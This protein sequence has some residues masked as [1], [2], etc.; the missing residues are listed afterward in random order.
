ME[1]C[2]APTCPI[3]GIPRKYLAAAR[4]KPGIPHKVLSLE[5]R[6]SFECDFPGFV[7]DAVAAWRYLVEDCGY[8]PENIVISGDSAGGELCHSAALLCLADTPS[9]NLTLALA[10]Y[11]RDEKPFGGASAKGLILHSV[12][13]PCCRICAK[14]TP[15]AAVD[16]PVGLLRARRPRGLI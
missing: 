5:Y 13:Q 4:G 7:Q 9:G 3:S 14:L 2:A 12:S 16:E 8:K 6:Q 15:A 10:R 11:L 1:F